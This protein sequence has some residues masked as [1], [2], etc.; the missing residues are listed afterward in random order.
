MHGKQKYS[1]PLEIFKQFLNASNT[2]V[3]SSAQ[4]P[5]FWITQKGGQFSLH[6]TAA[7][8]V[9]FFSELAVKLSVFHFTAAFVHCLSG[10][11]AGH[12]LRCAKSGGC[13]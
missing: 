1:P 13:Q 12:L 9:S 7:L 5:N 8:V 2:P 10:D 3:R 11:A 4:F 6:V